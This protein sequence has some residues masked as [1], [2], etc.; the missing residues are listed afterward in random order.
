MLRMAL[1]GV[2]LALGFGA[3]KEPARAHSALEVGDYSRAKISFNLLLNRSPQN[4]EYRQGLVLSYLQH[5]Q[6]SLNPMDL[7]D[8]YQAGKECVILQES[9]QRS[10][11]L[12]LCGR[13]F[14][15]SAY[16]YMRAGKLNVAMDWLHH[17]LN[18]E[19]QNVFALNLQAMILREWNQKQQAEDIWNL[20]QAQQ[21][22]FIPAYLHLGHLYW[23]AQDYAG[24]WF[25]W[26]EALQ[27]D[28]THDALLY[29]HQQAEIKLLE[30][31][32]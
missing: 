16:A 8:W 10:A 7:H 31:E 32:D 15:H 28:S 27:L 30:V 14:V 20:I 19:P 1:L 24:A 4:M 12:E 11:T 5:A 23:D 13:V 21:P 18:V 29:W 17:A 3:C 6:D 9:S 25:M 22:D 2:V 26:K